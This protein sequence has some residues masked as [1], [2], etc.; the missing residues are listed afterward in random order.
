MPK[1]PVK[2][3]PELPATLKE[4]YP[5]MGKAFGS[6]LQIKKNWSNSF[7][8]N[9]QTENSNALPLPREQRSPHKTNQPIWFLK[10]VR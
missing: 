4:G 9:N 6:V 5:R 1:R 2:G 3:T 8:A 10:N 7:F